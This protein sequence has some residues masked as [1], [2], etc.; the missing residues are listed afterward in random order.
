MAC[1]MGVWSDTVPPSRPRSRIA[2]AA[3]SR[4]SASVDLPLPDGP[5]RTTL[6]MAGSLMLT[7]PITG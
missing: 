6:R 7:P 5:T 4:A 2:P 3:N 1:S